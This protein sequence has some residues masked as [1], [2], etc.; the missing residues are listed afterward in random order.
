VSIKREQGISPL[1]PLRIRPVPAAA[2]LCRS[3]AATPSDADEGVTG[4]GEQ[5]YEID[6]V[7]VGFLQDVEILA[8][9]ATW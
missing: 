6:A 4:L 9:A 2:A 3:C 5:R 7:F 1:L 8:D